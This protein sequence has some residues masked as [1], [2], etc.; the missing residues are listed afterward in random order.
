MPKKMHFWSYSSLTSCS[1]SQLE[2]IGN[3]VRAIT[4]YGLKPHDI[5]EANDLFENVNHTQV[6]CTLIALAGMVRA[7]VAHAFAYIWCLHEITTGCTLL[8]DLDTFFFALDFHGNSSDLI[9]AIWVWKVHSYYHHFPFCLLR[10]G[11][12]GQVERFPLKVRYRGEVCREAA[13]TLRPREA[14][15]GTKHHRPAGQRGRKAKRVMYNFTVQAVIVQYCSPLQGCSLCVVIVPPAGLLLN[16]YS[17]NSHF[18]LCF[19]L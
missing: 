8:F 10:F 13:T 18:N 17:P 12:S 1:F 11:F 4:D 19:S 9:K 14:Q 2:N 7:A 3:F 5:F 15:G 6:Q 16:E